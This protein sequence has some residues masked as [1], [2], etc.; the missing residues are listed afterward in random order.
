MNNVDAFEEE[1]QHELMGAERPGI[2]SRFPHDLAAFQNTRIQLGV[3]G[4]YKAH[5][6]FATHLESTDC[7]DMRSGL[8]NM[9]VQGLL[10]ECLHTFDQP[11]SLGTTDVARCPATG[12]DGGGAGQEHEGLWHRPGVRPPE[13]RAVLGGARGAA[14]QARSRPGCPPGCPQAPR[15]LPALHN[16]VAHP[17][18]NPS[19]GVTALHLIWCCRLL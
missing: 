4:F 18:G 6:S 12:R 15:G 7:H 17:P 3:R 14:A 16:H 8:L 9:F 19:P 11:S 10:E 5:T 13:Q 1:M 2:R